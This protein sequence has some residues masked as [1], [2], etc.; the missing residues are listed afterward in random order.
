MSDQNKGSS[1][2]Q[3]VSAPK[4]AARN[5]S[6]S[7][8]M[9]KTTTPALRV[10]G[11][12]SA[13]VDR[14]KLALL[15]VT[16][17][18]RQDGEDVEEGFDPF[19]DGDLTLPWLDQNDVDFGKI[20]DLIIGAFEEG[21]EREMAEQDAIQATYEA[22]C[23][24]AEA[25]IAALTAERDAAVARAKALT[26]ALTPSADTKA[27]YISEVKFSVNTGF[28]EDGSEVWQEV[29]IPWDATKA[30]MAMIIGHAAM[31]ERS[32]LTTQGEG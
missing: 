12:T 1:Q 13:P 16:E 21:V 15:I 20:A 27:A 17:L 5:S 14:K 8:D 2:S 29:T 22:E 18:F 28:D 10:T 7:M 11:K 3:P 30:T 4:S 23:D 31:I 32:A 9:S 6:A 19:S 24:K 26:D 25:T